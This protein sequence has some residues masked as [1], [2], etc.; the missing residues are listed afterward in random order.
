EGSG[1]QL[2]MTPACSAHRPPAALLASAPALK[3]ACNVAVGC[4]DF[5]REAI[6][7]AGLMATDTPGLPPASRTSPPLIGAS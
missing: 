4:N 7:R 5:D 3:A 6:A 2:G 1:E